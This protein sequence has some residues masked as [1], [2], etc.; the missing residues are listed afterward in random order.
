MIKRDIASVRDIRLDM[1]SFTAE[2]T[3]SPSTRGECGIC[4][5]QT[6]EGKSYCPEHIE[7]MPYVSAISQ[8]IKERRKWRAEARCN[9]HEISPDGPLATEVLIYIT[10][11]GPMS[12]DRLARMLD[13]DTKLALSVARALRRVNKARITKGRRGA[14][15]VSLIV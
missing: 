15:V 14:K 8:E 4:K 5:A 1:A 7:R 13:V 9:P 10:V 12:I 11:D 2:K 6:R 3:R